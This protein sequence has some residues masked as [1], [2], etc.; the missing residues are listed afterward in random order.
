MGRGTT[1][2]IMPPQ[3]DGLTFQRTLNLAQ[4]ESPSTLGLLSVAVAED[5]IIHGSTSYHD[6]L[7]EEVKA[8]YDQ[9]FYVATIRGISGRIL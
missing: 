3:A 9:K 4:G 1:T 5:T 2:K 8:G 6:W 7:Q